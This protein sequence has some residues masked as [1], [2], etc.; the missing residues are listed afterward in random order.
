[1]TDNDIIR[2]I[3]EN[4]ESAWRELFAK[5][6][7]QFAP[8]ISAILKRSLATTYEDVYEQAC[9]DLMDNVKDG[10]LVEGE[11]VNISGY[12]YT[13]CW[14]RALRAENSQ[15]TQET[16]MDKM[17]QDTAE[18]EASEKYAPDVVMEYDPDSDAEAEDEAMAFLDKVLASIPESCRKLLRRFYWDKMPMKD[19]AAAMGLKNDD[20]AKATKNKCMNKFKSIAKAMLADDPKAEEAV[21]RTIER[22]ALRDLLDECR[23]EASGEW[24]MAALGHENELRK[25]SS[26]C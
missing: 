9:M 7:S 23:K 20:V 24:S 10:R 8:K 12:L 11:S 26:K 18:E 21:R 17:A 6:H 19:I 25:N 3:R 22:D 1:M 13:I 4:S 14:R 5:T 2:G 15:K 16:R